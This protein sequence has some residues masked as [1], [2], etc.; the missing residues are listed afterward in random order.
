MLEL[1]LM[2]SLSAQV[3]DWLGCVREQSYVA[4][5]VEYE[6]RSFL[7]WGEAIPCSRLQADSLFSKNI[8]RTSR[9]GRYDIILCLP[10]SGVDFSPLDST[11]FSIEYVLY[12]LR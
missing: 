6:H 5:L 9:S 4:W 3:P 12:T 11:T 7:R 8:H 1:G 2:G 10:I